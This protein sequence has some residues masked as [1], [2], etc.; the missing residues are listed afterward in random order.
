MSESEKIEKFESIVERYKDEI[1]HY[2]FKRLGYNK[3]L[4]DEVV[5]DVFMVLY[6]KWDQ[7][8]ISDNIRAFLYR[9]A[10]LIIKEKTRKNS[11]YY[12]RHT[13]L[14]EA[15]ELNPKHEQFSVDTYSTLNIPSL[16][17]DDFL[18][19]PYMLKFKEELSPTDRLLY[20]LRFEQHQTLMKVAEQS[21]MP[22]ST[23]R[24]HLID[25]EKKIREK[26]HELFL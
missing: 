18:S 26:I 25:I 2:S 8:D 14:E 19:T 10:E 6:R 12:K 16:N 5:N 4:A 23:V 24:L 17:V 13:S 22:Y 21:G 11:N 1:Y 15:E 9:T 7:L 20:E 3:W